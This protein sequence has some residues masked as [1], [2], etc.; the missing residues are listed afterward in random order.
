MK[1]SVIE[2]LRLF[3]VMS[4]F[5]DVHGTVL[6]HEGPWTN[7]L[8]DD[9]ESENDERS[10]LLVWEGV[11]EIRVLEVETDPGEV[12]TETQY[13]WHGAYRAPTAVELWRL[14]GGHFPLRGHA[15]PTGTKEPFAGPES[16]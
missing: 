2:G 15:F 14:G 9:H 3:C 4:P 7:D 11:C 5:S 13:V 8:F 1:S 12:G 16:T 10:G 6:D